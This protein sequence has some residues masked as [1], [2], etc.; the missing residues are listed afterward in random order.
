MDVVRP[1]L[2]SLQPEQVAAA[3]AAALA[4]G[5]EV[6]R[7][8]AQLL[9]CCRG[10]FGVPSGPF[11][12]ASHRTRGECAAIEQAGGAKQW[13]AAAAS[14]AIAEARMQ[15]RRDLADEL[16]QV[17]AEMLDAYG[18]AAGRT[19]SSR[20]KMEA[21]VALV[22]GRAAPSSAGSSLSNRDRLQTFTPSSRRRMA[23]TC[24]SRHDRPAAMR[25]RSSTPA[26][27]SRRDSMWLGGGVAARPSRR[28]TATAG[29]GRG[30]APRFATHAAR[31]RKRLGQYKRAAAAVR[32]PLRLLQRPAVQWLT[33]SLLRTP[34][35]AAQPTSC[36]SGTRDDRRA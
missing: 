34:D 1:L 36:V 6:T 26:R 35:C 32:P 25:S 28:S 18:A 19:H 15:F 7:L 16:Q 11:D 10:A 12:R 23:A 27:S 4:L 14:E 30:V 33:S 3:G 21:M 31:W 22:T 8:E 5:S 13:A 24:D 17:E 29:R 20:F 2:P 9:C